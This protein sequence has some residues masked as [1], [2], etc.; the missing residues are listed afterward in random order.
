[1]VPL[2]VRLNA[3]FRRRSTLIVATANSTASAVAKSRCSIL[4][5]WFTDHEPGGWL[6]QVRATQK[7][8]EAD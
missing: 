5:R 6:R 1:M 4:R 7:W 2:L 8:P 3:A